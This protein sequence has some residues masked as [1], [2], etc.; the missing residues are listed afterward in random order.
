M[1]YK[2]TSGL[3][4]CTPGSAPGPTVG[5]ECGS[6]L[7]LCVVYDVTAPPIWR[8]GQKP[9]NADVMEDDDVVFECNV[10]GRPRPTVTWM[11]NAQSL[12]QGLSLNLTLVIPRS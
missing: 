4:A 10:I 7:L 5:S 2:V 6:T 1:T 11:Y 9:Q 8:N 3:T 12:D